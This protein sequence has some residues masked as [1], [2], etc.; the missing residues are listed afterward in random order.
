MAFHGLGS[1]CREC[2]PPTGRLGAE[3]SELERERDKAR[4][5]AAASKDPYEELHCRE[6]AAHGRTS[7]LA[8]RLG[9]AVAGLVV[10]ILVAW[11]LLT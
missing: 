10:S 1:S 5:A 3:R 6:R 4:D 11:L 2:L 9:V 8:S 7:D